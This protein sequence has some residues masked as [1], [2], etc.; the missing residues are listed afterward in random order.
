M[1]PSPA[2][3]STIV[4]PSFDTAVGSAPYDSRSLTSSRSAENAARIRAVANTIRGDHPGEVGRRLHVA[5]IHGPEER[6]E[7]LRVGAVHLRVVVDQERREL[8][9]AV[10]HGKPQR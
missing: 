10:E 2:A 5:A 7:P 3:A 8:V 4:S 9:I 6:R 1:N